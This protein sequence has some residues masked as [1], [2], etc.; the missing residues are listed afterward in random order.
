M[1]GLDFSYFWVGMTQEESEACRARA[2][3]SP[4]LSLYLDA[5][6]RRVDSLRRFEE[7]VRLYIEREEW[8][9]D[10]VGLWDRQWGSNDRVGYALAKVWA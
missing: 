7:T 5:E 2:W 4:W 1:R 3:L 6:S 10:P 9:R 8:E